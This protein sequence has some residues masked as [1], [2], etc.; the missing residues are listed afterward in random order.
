TLGPDGTPSAEGRAR[1]ALALEVASPALR[2]VD[3]SAQLATGGVTS[4]GFIGT[5]SGNFDKGFLPAVLAQLKQ[6]GSLPALDYVTVHFYS[7]QSDMY[8]AAGTDLLGRVSQLRQDVMAAGLTDTELKPVIS[9][10]LSYT[11]SI[12]TSSNDPN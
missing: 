11:D 9:D 5:P 12:A 4:G 1:Y 2:S 10:E 3:G 8:A 6:D 7:S